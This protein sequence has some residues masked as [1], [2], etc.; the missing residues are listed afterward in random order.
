MQPSCAPGFSKIGPR[1]VSNLG[2]TVERLVSYRPF[3]SGDVGRGSMSKGG[4]TNGGCNDAISI[5]PAG[6]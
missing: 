2:G 3:S 1:A 5:I 4:D 6:D